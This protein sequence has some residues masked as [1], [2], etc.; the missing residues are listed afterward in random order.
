M[1]AA[2]RD[3]RQAAALVAR[4]G[5]SATLRDPRGWTAA[6]SL[7][8]ETEAADIGPEAAYETRVTAYAA[9][10]DLDAVPQEGAS[11]VSGTDA[12]LV[13]D[14]RDDGHGIVTMT[15]RQDPMA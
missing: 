3:T 14:A 8:V 7:V 1:S 13:D 15:L 6:V 11:V 10:G 4:D 2:T 12:W 5:R 9:S